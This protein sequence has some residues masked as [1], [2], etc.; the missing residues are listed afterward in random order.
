MKTVAV[1]S[2]ADADSLHTKMADEAYNIGPP[3]A[4]ESYLRADKILEICHRSGAQAV[5]PGYGFLSENATFADA[6]R[7][8]G[9][10]LIGPPASAMRDMGSKS[11][12]KI[13]MTAANVP[14]VPGYHGDD[15]SMERLRHE[16][17]K[18]GYPIMIK[19]VLGGGGKGMRIVRHSGELVESIEACR[20]EAKKSF[21]S[22]LV[23]MER[24]IERP[25]H[26]EF[27]V[28]KQP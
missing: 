28:G 17:E 4:A 6:C 20:R 8:S 9:V 21:N 10:I 14:V 24:Y 25:R 3:A 1:F 5:H 13:I 18:V 22:E 19:A 27:Q 15:Q 16:A 23:L 2:D 7:D 12:S 11:A 26:I